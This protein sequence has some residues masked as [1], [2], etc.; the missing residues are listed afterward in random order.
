VDET[1]D[2]DKKNLGL[3]RSAFLSPIGWFS[4]CF[5]I[6]RVSSLLSS[7]LP[8]KLQKGV[9]VFPFVKSLMGS[10]DS[11]QLCDFF[12]HVNFVRYLYPSPSR[13]GL[14][15]VGASDSYRSRPLLGLS[16]GDW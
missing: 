6:V 5:T 8:G 10:V 13:Y 7:T 14:L 12:S 1:G 2:E 3:V 15:L 16:F 11:L 9:L 4:F